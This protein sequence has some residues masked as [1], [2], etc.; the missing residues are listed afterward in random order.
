M[1]DQHS[2]DDMVDYLQG[3]PSLSRRRFG[4]LA[5]GSLLAW[6]AA[7]AAGAPAVVE[8]EVDI[9]T[10]DGVCDAYFVHPAKGKYPAVIMW[11]DIGGLRPAFRA[12][13][14]RLAEAGY[15]VLVPNPFYRRGRVATD[16]KMPNLGDPAAREAAFANMRSLTPTTN[17][18]DAQAFVPWL[19]AQPAVNKRRKMGT[20]GYCMGGPFTL[21][22]AAAFP[23]RIG[24]GASFHGAGLASKNPDSPHL[25]VPKIKASFLIAIAEN[26]D[27]QDPNAKLLLREAFDAAKLPAEIE[28][29]KGSKHGWCPPDSSVYDEALAEKA[30]ARCLVL[31]KKALG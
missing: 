21:R 5:A 27:Q 12:M 30:W 23:D 15:A 3:S 4:S 1:C 22:T 29:Y 20:M 2:A 9:K 7:R 19:D 11:P 17:L 10:A 18:T 14:K 13:G 26:D 25:L 31:F 8:A 16:A 6:S 28:V 24:A